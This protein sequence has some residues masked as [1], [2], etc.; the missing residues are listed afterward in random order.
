MPD[1]LGYGK[2]I[3]DFLKQS[4][5]LFT[6]FLRQIKNMGYEIKEIILVE[7]KVVVNM[8]FSKSDVFAG[9]IISDLH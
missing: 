8:V 1:H 7:G 2:V 4:E 3:F 5:V 6:L 9:C